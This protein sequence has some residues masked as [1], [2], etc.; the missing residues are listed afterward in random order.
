VNLHGVLFCVRLVLRLNASPCLHPL[1]VPAL[2]CEQKALSSE[3]WA[4]DAGSAAPRCHCQDQG[5]MRMSIHVISYARD[6][7]AF[8]CCRVVC[9]FDGCLFVSTS[10]IMTHGKHGPSNFSLPYARSLK[11]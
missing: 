8:V 10:E 6:S 2:D 4:L 1:P 3:P 11:L 5:G 9:C 7:T